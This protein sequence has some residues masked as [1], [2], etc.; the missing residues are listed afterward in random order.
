M[1][2]DEYKAPIVKVHGCRIAIV[3]TYMMV[4]PTLANPCIPKVVI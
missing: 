3:V 1:V 2:P 4:P